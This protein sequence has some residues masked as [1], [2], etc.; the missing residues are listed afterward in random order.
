MNTLDFGDLSECVPPR[1]VARWM[2]RELMRTE[3]VNRLTAWIAWRLPREI[4]AWAVIRVWMFASTGKWSAVGGPEIT[5]AEA[6]ERWKEA[7][8]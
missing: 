4:V 1:P 6:L 2:W 5:L 8:E 7:T 3:S